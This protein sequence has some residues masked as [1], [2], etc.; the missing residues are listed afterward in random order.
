MEK[1]L[2]NND[3]ATILETTFSGV[4]REIMKRL[5]TQK[6]KKNPGAYPPELRSFA[7]TLK[8][9][10]AKAYNYVRKSFDLG[11]PCPFVIRS[12]YSSMN[13][14]PGFTKDGM[15]A[16]KAKVL[17]AKRDGQEVV[18]TLML[19]EMAIRKHVEWDGKRF[20]GFVD[21]G[22]GIDDDS[23]P[24]ATDAL[25]FMAVAVNS[26]WKVPCGYFLANGLSGNEKANLTK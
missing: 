15:T 17:A 19:D 2:I 7:M 13:G 26:C 25:V 23:A 4:P 20:R 9:Y 10:S 1:N 18:C 14:V 8:F 12:W 24:E 11:L 21:L 3:C 5:V 22:T 16:M 6:E